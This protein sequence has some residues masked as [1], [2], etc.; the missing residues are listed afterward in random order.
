MHVHGR[1]V[2][3]Y[4]NFFLNHLRIDVNEANGDFQKTLVL[5]HN[6]DLKNSVCGEIKKE[7]SMYL[8][9][10][11]DTSYIEKLWDLGYLP[12]EIRAL[13][14]GTFWNEIGD[15]I[16]FKMARK[17]KG[18]ISRK[19]QNFPIQGS[20]SDISKYALIL[21]FKEILKQNLLNV[22]LIGNFVH[23]EIVLDVPE[24]LAEEWAIILQDCMEQAG[25]PFCPIIPL[26]AEAV[27]SDYW[28]H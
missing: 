7:L 10:E 22:V 27:I 5:K 6:N 4:N 3:S 24:H 26:K 21:V 15:P 11:Y 12:L 14:E 8:N 20:S 1:P 16:A 23:D 9:T 28:G 18:E 17:A 13:E 25:K 19:S 2:D